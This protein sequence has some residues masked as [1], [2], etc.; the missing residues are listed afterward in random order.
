MSTVKFLIIIFIIFNY[1][2]NVILLWLTRFFFKLEW[3]NVGLES[4][5]CT[6]L[7]LSLPREQIHIIILPSP[8]LQIHTQINCNP[9]FPHARELIHSGPAEWFVIAIN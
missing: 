5:E 7:V 4:A 6:L 1:F 3:R 9:F 8:A 2:L